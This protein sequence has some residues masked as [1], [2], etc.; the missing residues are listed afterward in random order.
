MGASDTASINA[1]EIAFGTDLDGDGD[2]G[3]GFTEVESS[4]SIILQQDGYGRIYAN[5]N[6]ILLGST[7]LTAS[8]YASY[9]FVAAEDFGVASGG[10]QLVLK[11]SSGGFATWSLDDSWRRTGQVDWVGASDIF[12][13]NAK[14]FA[15]ATDLDEDGDVGL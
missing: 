5:N 1:K 15:F 10:K 8:H 11:H 7:H 13:I 6:P 4:G 2:I 14:E 3:A 9:T 12:G